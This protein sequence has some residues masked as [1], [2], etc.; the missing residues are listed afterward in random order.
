MTL[1]DNRS[2]RSVRVVARP[3]VIRRSQESEFIAERRKGVPACQIDPRLSQGLIDTVL[4]EPTA[5][6]FNVEPVKKIELP[7]PEPHA[8]DTFVCDVC[9]ETVVTRYAREREGQTVCIPCAAAAAEGRPVPLP[10]RDG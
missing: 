1:I 4:S 5:A 8:F 2:A 3:A 9:G 6:L 7:P 10:V